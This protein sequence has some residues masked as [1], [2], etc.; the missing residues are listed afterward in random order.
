MNLNQ[1]DS[2]GPLMAREGDQ[3]VIIG[4]VSFGTGCGVLP[5]IYVAIG[6]VLDWIESVVGEKLPT[7]D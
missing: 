6:Q 3:T 7:P 5:S 1:G 2:G 4:T